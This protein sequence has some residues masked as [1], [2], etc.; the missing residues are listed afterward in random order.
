MD[1]RDRDAIRYGIANA[2]RGGL[3]RLTAI[4]GTDDGIHIAAI[5][6]ERALNTCRVI[7]DDGR[8]ATVC[9]REILHVG[10][11]GD[12]RRGLVPTTTLACYSDIKTVA[13]LERLARGVCRDRSRT[14]RSQ[15]YSK[16]QQEHEYS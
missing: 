5:Q 9:D 15:K 11:P 3:P 4:G 7:N 2:S 6:C 16:R 14:P 1:E 12:T 8:R 13:I 10:T